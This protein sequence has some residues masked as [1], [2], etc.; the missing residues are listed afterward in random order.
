MG[1]KKVD[2]VE[3]C[4]VE[5]VRIPRPP[6]ESA[7]GKLPPGTERVLIGQISTSPRQ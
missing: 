4:G 5:L 2:N 7:G 3:V 6:M 1:Y